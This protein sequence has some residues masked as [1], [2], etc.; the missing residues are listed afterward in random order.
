MPFDFWVDEELEEEVEAVGVAD[1]LLAELALPDFAEG[2]EDFVVEEVVF[3]ASGFRLPALAG[4]LACV[5]LLP[6]PPLPALISDEASDWLEVDPLPGDD[7]EEVFWLPIELPVVLIPDVAEFEVE[8]CAWFFCSF[9]ITRVGIK[10]KEQIVDLHT[11]LF[12]PRSRNQ[13]VNSCYLTIHSTRFFPFS[14]PHRALY[15][16]HCCVTAQQNW[17]LVAQGQPWLGRK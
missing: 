2:E 12:R 11:L 8:D 15:W 13:R 6:S 3:L 7:V 5:W 14:T 1:F 9:S 4:L 16:P 17:Q 10:V